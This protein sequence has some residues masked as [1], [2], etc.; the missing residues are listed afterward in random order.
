MDQDKK[1]NLAQRSKSEEELMST[2]LDAIQDE[3]QL[4]LK[5]KVNKLLSI[6]LKACDPLPLAT[7]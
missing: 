4:L 3:P 1:F 7:S 5:I 6:V 2:L